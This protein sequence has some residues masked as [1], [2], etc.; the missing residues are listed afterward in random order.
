M[1]YENL[2]GTFP[3]WIDGNLAITSANGNPVT[4][5]IG[6]ASRGDSET[7]YRVD[8]PSAASAKFGRVDGTLARGMYEVIAG[9]AENLRLY[10]MGAK[11]AKLTNVGGGITI[12]TNAKDAGAGNLY[13]MFWDDSE[14]RLKIWRVSDGVL[15]YDNNPA[16]PSDVVDENELSI[17]GSSPGATS[18]DIGSLAYPL[19]LAQAHGVGSAAYTAGNDGI[20]LSRMEKYENLFQA[21]KL[22]ENQDM[23]IIVPMDVY[24]DDP[25]VD[26]MDNTGVAA[27]NSSAPWAS[28]S[29]YPTP[30]THHDALGELFAQEYLGQW[31]F[32]WDMDRDGVAEIWP[33]SVGSASTTTDCFGNALDA[34][35]FHPV[36]FAYQLAD[37]CYRQSEDNA[38]MIGVIGVRPPASWSLK[39][40][41]AWIGRAPT[42]VESGVNLVVETNGTGLL[43]SRWFGGKKSLAGSGTMGHT[44]DS[45]DGLAY[46]GFIATDDGWMDGVQEKDRNDRLVDIGKYISTVGA[47]SILSNPTHSTA[48]VA[49]GAAV[50]AGMISSLPVNSAP[51]NKLISGVRLPFR[52]SVAK[53]DA[54]AGSRLVMFQN[55]TKGTVVADAPTAARPGSDYARLTTV[56]I[57]KATIDVVRAVADPFIGEALTGAKL[58]ALETAIDRGLAKETKA[59][60]LQRYD[61]KVIA[62]A[63]ERVQGKANVELVLVPAF[64]LRQLT[65]YIALAAQ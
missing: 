19:T 41:S 31:Y 5:V 27:L 21:Y 34:S 18:V 64:E 24:V 11:A 65:I 35:D 38:E 14:G 33:T 48:Y 36:N 30:L 44:V 37:F 42:Y 54:L 15:V 32:W 53:L 50:Y 61:A 55:K 59:S 9:G 28:S 4:V 20:L 62:T 46:G 57:V 6:T 23:D 58:A 56:R 17:T 51:T 40:V 60:I 7:F 13:N 49:T 2:P 3:K 47:Y 29:V 43:G 63:S 39:D 26:D 45:I 8:S 16:Y 22:L 52:I 12:E 25:N 1:S 10:R